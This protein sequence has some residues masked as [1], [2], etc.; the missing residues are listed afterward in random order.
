LKHKGHPF[1]AQNTVIIIIPEPAHRKDDEMAG[2]PLGL[3]DDLL[4]H[5]IVG[6]LDILQ[7]DHVGPGGIALVHDLE[8]R[9]HL[10]GFVADVK[11]AVIPLP[12]GSIQDSA[13]MDEITYL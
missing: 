4:H 3:V 13:R 10:P 6:D 5:A 8:V 12:A 7:L 9:E 1:A 11:R 2:S